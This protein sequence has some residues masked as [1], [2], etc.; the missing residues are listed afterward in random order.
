[1]TPSALTRDVDD[2]EAE[3]AQSEFEMSS[4]DFKQIAETLHAESGI[5]IPESKTAL[6]YS[7]LA[8]RLRALGLQSF[9]DYCSLIA[10]DDGVEERQRMI[11]ALTTN[12]TAFF[13]EPH[14]FEHLE[15]VVAP[16][17]IAAA[18]RGE[19]VRLWSSACSSGEEPYSIAL[20][21]LSLAPNV[22]NLD[23]KVLATDIDPN[24]V[25]FGERGIY[26]TKALANAPANLR[27]RWFR[28]ARGDAGELRAADELRRLVA[29]KQLNL[30]GSWPMKGRF[31]AIFCRNVVIYFDQPTQAK[32][33]SRFGSALAPNGVLYIGHSERLSGPAVAAFKSEGVTTYRL[34]E[35]ARP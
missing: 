4:R 12:V 14:H 3:L 24:M 23:I 13:R 2:G 1:L 33:W 16:P 25:A 17:L 20:T 15:T 22:V 35:G 27:D 28:A 8:K 18:Q 32:L 10:G 5:F 34:N 31:Q 6:V 9:R 29:F 30:I 19:R 21:L 11:A 26:P 7:R